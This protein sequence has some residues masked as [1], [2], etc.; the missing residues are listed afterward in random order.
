[1]KDLHARRQPREP[2]E[3]FT[4]H[5]PPMRPRLLDHAGR[6]E[7]RRDVRR[8]ADDRLLTNARGQIGHAVHAVLQ[9]QDGVSGPSSGATSG[10][11]VALS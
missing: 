10:S 4:E 2:A 5:D 7:R 8:S 3:H 6:A 11:A 1:M 9:R